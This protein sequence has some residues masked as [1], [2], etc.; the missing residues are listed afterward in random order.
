MTSPQLSMFDMP[1]KPVKTPRAPAPPKKSRPSIQKR[2]DEFAL[3]NPHVLTA[4]LELARSWL[5]RGDTYISAKALYEQMRTTVATTI[6][7]GA[8][9]YKLNNDFTPLLSRWLQDKE[10]RLIG[11]LRMR[12]RK[13]P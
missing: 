10:P 11:V 9:S 1:P 4:A 8:I 6:G 12:E 7:P 2:F 13:A 5:D 3:N